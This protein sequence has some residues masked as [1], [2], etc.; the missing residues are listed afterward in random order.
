MIMTS[1]LNTDFPAPIAHGGNLREVALRYGIPRENWIDLSTGIN[2]VGYPVPDIDA[3]TWLRLPDD[4]DDLEE[5][6]AKH[7]GA[8]R[9]LATP[10][11]QAAIRM[12]PKVLPPGRIGIG[13]VTYGEYEQVFTAAGFPIE[14]FVTEA[15]ADMRD[16]AAFLLLPGQP[17]PAGL[18]HLVL[19]TPN[20][21]G[22]ERFT[23]QTLL[24]WHRELAQRGGTLIVD[25][26]F[27]DATPEFSVAVD[28]DSD[29]LIVLRSV[30]KFFGLGG[31]RVGFVLSGARV[32]RAMRYL[33]G[34]WTVSGPARFVTRA[35]LL[36]TAW[37][38]QARAQLVDSSARL[39]SLLGKYGLDAY[40]AHTPLFVW[41]RDVNARLWQEG[42]ARHGIWVR[43]FD[44]AA[45]LR[46]GLPAGEL[47]WTRIEEALRQ[48][49]DELK[50]S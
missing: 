36:D 14:H 47:A 28:S 18:K 19:V 26:A 30:G 32:H 13:L 22:A 20:N 41:A 8:T 1:M 34:Q 23:P 43:R 33:R 38:I 6:A 9:A 42:L 7:Y 35:A 27:I 4:D 40:H 10:G 46:F 21:P 11:T 50:G 29:N 3:N 12:L 24:G 15:F 16:S 39:V 2:P 48:V 44:T 17:L 45:G 25:E 49:R 31:A 37:Q 5:V